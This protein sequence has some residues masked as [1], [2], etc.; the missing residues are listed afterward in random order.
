MVPYTYTP[1]ETEKAEIRMIQLAPGKAEDDIVLSLIHAPLVKP[2]EP[3]EDPRLSIKELQKTLPDDWLVKKTLNGRY[4]FMKIG[5]GMPNSWIHPD[6]SFDPAYKPEYE[7]L[8][9]TWGS[10]EN[11]VLAIVES[12]N[13]TRVSTDQKT[14]Y[15]GQN[16]A[17]ALRFLRSPEN[18][19][20]LWVD[21][22]CINQQDINERN[23]QVRRMGDI[24]SLA[25][26]VIIWLGPE[27]DNSAHAL[28]TLSYF[29][30]QVECTIDEWVCDAPGAVEPQWMKP[31]YALP[32]DDLT[33]TAVSSLFYRP[34]FTRVWVLQEA[35]LA[36]DAV[37]Q[38]GKQSI[39]W[40]SLRKAM[41][42]LEDKLTLS[43]QLS[44]FLTS[45]G[46]ALRGKSRWNLP[47]LLEWGGPRQCTDP[48][49]K[50]YGILNMLSPELSRAIT[51]DYNLETGE[52]FKEAILA[53]MHLTKRVNLLRHCQLKNR[54]R[55]CPSWVPG[56]KSTDNFYRV[57]VSNARQVSGYSASQLEYCAPDI[58]RVVGLHGGVVA[59][60]TRLQGTMGDICRTIRQCEPDGLFRDDYVDGE[61]LLGAFLE[62]VTGGQLRER[63]PQSLV[64]TLS[65]LRNGYKDV[66]SGNASLDTILGHYKRNLELQGLWMFT[67]QDGRLGAARCE[68][69][70]GDIIGV[71]LGCDEPLLLRS[72][73]PVTQYYLVGPCFVQGF[74]D[75]ERFLGALQKPWRLQIFGDDAV[76]FVPWYYNDET[77]ASTREDPRLPPLSPEWTSMQRK[78]AQEDSY[79]LCEFQN[80]ETGETINY[81]PRMTPEA[82]RERGVQLQTFDLV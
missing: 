12:S 72:F 3:P 10:S 7:A 42:V 27:G 34:W 31:G 71:M 59:T 6:P 1:L 54:M 51:V 69:K 50:I 33:W 9:Y 67:T 11:P 16:L 8:S 41:L 18:T 37:V 44:A 49:D 60:T 28:S 80:V 81:D 24:Y 62:V 48:R 74:M 52:L 47:R 25:K 61:P 55:N 2:Q 30:Q 4:L 68:V 35:L 65:A 23:A 5:T 22:V 14:L 21:A 13:D 57:S 56:W 77:K 20:T 64:P 46:L 15:I 45:Y 19:R 58:L 26:K 32:Y 76:I 53:H 82:L 73:S 66:E 78:R 38:C 79:S 40:L 39:D 63:F 70:P 36:R 75:G 29:A 17:G 43:S